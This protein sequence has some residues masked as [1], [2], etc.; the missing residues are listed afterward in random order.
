MRTRLKIIK[1][2]PSMITP[3][4][5]LIEEHAYTPDSIFW[6][7]IE[8]DVDK[9]T[10]H[11]GSIFWKAF[12]SRGPVVPLFT[13]TSAT[14]RKGIYQPSQVGLTHPTGGAILDRLESFQVEIPKEW[15][16]LQDH[17]KRGIV[18]CLPQVYQP[19]EVISFAVSVIPIVSPFKFEG[20]LNLFYPDLLQ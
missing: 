3:A 4:V 9:S 11:T 6:V 1:F 2:S 7:N 19:E 14:D 13:W 16:L 5:K 20:S 12:S 17:P 18:F 15:Q 8:P 10:I